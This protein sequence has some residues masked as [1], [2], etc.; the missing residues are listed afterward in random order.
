MTAYPTTLDDILSP[1]N[2]GALTAR[3]LG[4]TPHVLDPTCTEATLWTGAVYR[5]DKRHSLWILHDGPE[6][7]LSTIT[8]CP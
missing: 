5:W 2:C 1:F 6:T 4:S 8:A 7:I 3:E